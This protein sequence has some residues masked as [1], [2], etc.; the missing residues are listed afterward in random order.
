MH[1]RKTRPSQVFVVTGG[2]AGLVPEM[3]CDHGLPSLTFHLF[4]KH[5]GGEGP[6]DIGIVMPTC[7]T[8]Q[9]VGAALAFLKT[10]VGDD[11]A[12]TF[13]E[14]VHAACDV[15]L[16]QLAVAQAATES[17]CCEAGVRSHGREHTCRNS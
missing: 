9:L 15:A 8:A 12:Q 4:S 14:E 5:D 2:G 17:S 6:Q 7:A 16:R 1:I 13:V 10:Y 3:P 11:S